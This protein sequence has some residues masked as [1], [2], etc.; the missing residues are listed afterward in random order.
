MRTTSFAGA[1]TLLIVITAMT[2]GC[3]DDFTVLPR[4]HA[5]D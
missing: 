5:V 3:G 1:C 2:I 4:G